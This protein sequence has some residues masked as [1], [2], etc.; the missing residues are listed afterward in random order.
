MTTQNESGREL[1]VAAGG[2]L[3]RIGPDGPQCAIVFR[4][5]YQGEPG[6]PKGKVN[7]GESLEQA[8][9]R[10]VREETGYEAIV[11]GYVGST[12]Y[13][14]D[15][16]QKVVFFWSLAASGES[17]FRPSEEIEK[18]EWLTAEAAMETL[19]H[20]EERKVMSTAVSRVGAQIQAER[21]RWLSRLWIK[22]VAS[23][24]YDRLEGSLRVAQI[25]IE[26]R[27]CV[28]LR[29]LADQPAGQ[30]AGR[31]ELP[32][33]LCWAD[34]AQTLV[35]EARNALARCQIDQGWR[36]L[37]AARRMELHALDGTNELPA[38][39]AAL[40]SETAK[41]KSWRQKAVEELVGTLQK[42]KDPVRVGEVQRA[43][44]VRDEH[45]DN[46]AYK[47]GLLRTQILS[48][49][50]VLGAIMA[51]LLAVV[52]AWGLPPSPSTGDGAFRT[53][54][55]VA[56]FGLLG[57]TVSAMIRASDTSQSARIPELIAAVRVTFMRIFMGSAAAVVIYVALNSQLRGA[58]SSELFGREPLQP[59]TMYVVAFVAGFSERLVMRAVEH[60]VGK[61]QEKSKGKEQAP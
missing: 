28:H 2:I 13:A 26:Q 55:V 14:Y 42:P 31:T 8:A 59:Y 60:V 39:A 40:R 41:L 46:Q 15:H 32:R 17:S 6:L 23:A 45:Y 21:F 33:E 25:E 12:S 3:W 29:R 38:A 30:T 57:G 58:F 50:L 24:R 27:V 16:T 35:F 47:D 48:L 11:L 44:F 49:V 22:T 53:F 56:L 51:V 43:A 9:L 61:D 34:A 1:V 10:E 19:V 5:R 37:H 52:Q 54:I 18:I 36:L 20:A 7:P 4:R